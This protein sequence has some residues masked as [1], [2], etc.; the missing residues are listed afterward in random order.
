MEDSM[1][2]AVAA[3]SAIALSSARTWRRTQLSVLGE[4]GSLT[5]SGSRNGMEDWFQNGVC[6][7][8]GIGQVNTTYNMC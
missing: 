1:Q 4:V 3:S 8:W 2:G 6:M 5:E 7:L